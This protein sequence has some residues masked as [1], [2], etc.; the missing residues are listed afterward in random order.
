MPDTP[1]H[2]MRTLSVHPSVVFKL[3]EDLISDDVQA[4]VE[5]VK[6]SWDAGAD[7]AHVAIDTAAVMSDASL[8]SLRGRISVRDTGDGMT[9]SEIERGWLTISNS[10]K[11]EQK[12]KGVA[13][14]KRVPL[15]DKG[16]GR[17]GAQRLGQILQMHT[18]PRSEDAAYSVQIRWTDYERA[19]RLVDVPISIQTPRRAGAP[20]GTDI[21]IRGLRDP[22]TWSSDNIDD[23]Q[24]RLV[25]LVSPFGAD[26][27]FSVTV[28][29]DGVDLGIA[30][31]AESLRDTAAARYWFSYDDGSMQISAR[32]SQRLASENAEWLAMDGGDSFLS[33]WQDSSGG[34]WKDLGLRRSSGNWILE[35]TKTIALQDIEPAMTSGDE[36]ADPGPFRGEI[37]FHYLRGSSAG[38]F[39]RE[40]EYRDW[41]RLL[42]GIQ[43]YRDGFG[44]NMP[45]DWLGL[46]RAATGGRS[47]YGL[48]PGNVVGFVEISARDNPQLEEKT[49]RE[50]FRETAAQRNFMT[51]LDKTR[52][53]ADRLQESFRRALNDFVREQKEADTSIDTSTAER[54]VKGVRDQVRKQRPR[55]HPTDEGVPSDDEELDTALGVLELQIG[56]LREQLE[57]AYET[58]SLGITAEALT[59]EMTMIAQR[60]STMARQIRRSESYTTLN[61][62][63]QHFIGEVGSAATALVKQAAHLNPSLRYKR[64]Q[65]DDFS[66]GEFCRD[67]AKFHD[68]RYRRQDLQVLCVIEQNFAIRMNRGRLTQVLDNLLINS[69]HWLREGR[70]LGRQESGRATV[71]VSAP[72]ILVDDDGPGISPS[73]EGSLFDPFVSTRVG[74]RGLGL[75]VARQLLDPD[76]ATLTLTDDRNRNGR[77]YR[78]RIDLAAVL[79]D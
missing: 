62:Q 2:E 59:H 32:L 46:G 49:D 8:G 56:S 31:L 1:L 40:S 73:V 78:F 68:D 63:V 9:L 79:R 36:I 18:R 10:D 13:K 70:R 41:I 43:L 34:S 19:E 47:L 3:G 24:R 33:W 71:T 67:N 4:L 29:I 74:G 57:V 64:E 60:L 22:A 48:R 35:S 51:L 25:R 39:D 58:M 42:R 61:P 69:M 75:F 30:E 20:N 55:P 65:K 7:R 45:E 50:G 14:G 52:D 38:V 16:L 23:L 72:H 17:L 28:S 11:R 21:E 44:I 6:N 27:G 26:R 12:R 54:T 37:D 76:G 5:L 15:G 77:R 66:V 53:Y